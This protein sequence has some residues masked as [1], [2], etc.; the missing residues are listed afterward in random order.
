MTRVNRFIVLEGIDG[1]GKST[2]IKLLKQSLEDRGFRVFATREP[3]GTVIGEK[4]RAI[5]LDKAHSDM[6]L[7]TEALLYA[8]CRAQ[9]V[10]EVILPRLTLGEIVLCERYV[11][12][13]LAYQ[14]HGGGLDREW[15]VSINR[16]ACN[17]VYPSLTILLDLDPYEH[18]CRMKGTDRIESRGLEYLRRVREGYLE[19]ARLDPSVRVVS[20]AASVEEVHCAILWEALSFLS[21]G[22]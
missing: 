5:L 22:Q 18:Q 2:Q 11:L 20:A 21:G 6:K 13:S 16:F 3:G 9:L 15:V 12:S 1:S 19:E 7:R 14:A 8:A 4:V 17:G 10:E